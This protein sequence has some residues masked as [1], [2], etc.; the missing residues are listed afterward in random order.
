[1]KPLSGFRMLIPI[2][3]I[4]LNMSVCVFGR[5]QIKKCYRKNFFSHNLAVNFVYRDLDL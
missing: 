1:M 5:R 3:L 2:S 4:V